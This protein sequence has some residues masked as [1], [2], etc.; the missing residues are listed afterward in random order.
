MTSIP[1]TLTIFINTRIRNN[2][3]IKYNPSMTVP[4]IKSDIICFDP[5]IKLNKSIVTNIPPDQPSEELYTQ[6]FRRNE[7]NS[8][9]QR[10]LS[11][12]SQYPHDLTGAKVEGIIDQN[13]RTTLDILFK[14]GSPFYINGEQYTIHSYDWVTGDWKIDTK[15]FEKYVSKGLPYLNVQYDRIRDN[16]A[17]KE[18]L[19]IPNDVQVGNVPHNSS[20]IVKAVAITEG[21]PLANVKIMT[22][23]QKPAPIP[24]APPLPA[25]MYPPLSPSTIQETTELP[26]PVP[27]S[28]RVSVPAP[29]PIPT[30]KGRPERPIEPSKNI[31][32]PYAMASAN[33]L[34]ENLSPVKTKVT[35]KAIELIP[36]KV[37]TPEEKLVYQLELAMEQGIRR[38]VLYSQNNVINEET[39]KAVERWELAKNNGEG[40]CLFYAMRDIL[41]SDQNRKKSENPLI[42]PRRM[43]KRGNMVVLNPNPYLDNGVYTVRTLRKAL[44]DYLYYPNPE[45][46]DSLQGHEILFQQYLNGGIAQWEAADPNTL[47]GK[48][49]KM[50]WQFIRNDDNTGFIT[51]SQLADLIGTPSDPVNQLIN[52]DGPSK[53]MNRYYLGDELAVQC[54]ED[55]F[56][57]KIVLMTDPDINALRIGVRVN[58]FNGTGDFHT[59]NVKSYNASTKQCVIETDDYKLYEINENDADIN[60]EIVNR[61]TIYNAPS[62]VRFPKPRID[63][64]QFVFIFYTQGG[65]GHYEAMYEKTPQAGRLTRSA[66]APPLRFIFDSVQM[67]GY[68]KYMIYLASYGYDMNGN[69]GVRNDT[70]PRIPVL[71][72][73]LNKMYQIVLRKIDNRDEPV[74]ITSGQKV[75]LGGALGNFVSSYLQNAPH[76]R[77][78]DTKL[79]FYVII[80]LEVY[81][82]KSISSSE[83]RMLSC[84][85]MYG[86]IMSTYADMHGMIYM[87]PELS[88]PKGIVALS[89]KQKSKGGNKN[90]TRRGGYSKKYVKGRAKKRTRRISRRNKT[91]TRKVGSSLSQK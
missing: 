41:S 63:P 28:A 22:P 67:P 74:K 8:L 9:L 23:V 14:S 20:K 64:P 7:F 53:P 54:F 42:V 6:F 50:R 39:L 26:P 83:K 15:L 72:T 56:G 68:I 19:S 81:P 10:T 45:E 61:Y 33:F 59:G 34:A 36:N 38:D 49:T 91:K 70:Y 51:L 30:S 32:S 35:D 48:E 80:D 16:N 66:G 62:T 3:R 2:N 29:A 5:L 55:I 13:I 11:G 85:S 86:K 78:Y 46:P 17:K 18:L 65:I 37:R 43:D 57:T 4:N 90:N 40:D 69:Y 87:P 60:I 71:N 89:Y 47:L 12:K 1:N 82:G 27:Q 75:Q 44:K 21:V 31:A 79:T 88:M 24:S 52:I 58:F 77:F 25:N 76:I 73:Y 84:S